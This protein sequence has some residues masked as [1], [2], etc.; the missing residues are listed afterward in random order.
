MPLWAWLLWCRFKRTEQAVMA[1]T[2]SIAIV[3][4]TY[5]GCEYI[6]DLFHSIAAQTVLPTEI[7]VC[8]DCSTDDTAATVKRLCRELA[9][10]LRFFQNERNIGFSASFFKAVSYARSEFIFFCDQDDYWHPDKINACTKLMIDNDD[11]MGVT[12]DAVIADSNLRQL[13]YTKFERF[14]SAYP[15]AQLAGPVT[16][17]LTAIRGDLIGIYLPVVREVT[18]DHWLAFIA[19]YFHWRWEFIEIPLQLVRRHERNTS[20][21]VIYKSGLASPFDLAMSQKSTVPAESYDDRI[22]VIDTLY[23]RLRQSEVLP[24][25][26]TMDEVDG[27]LSQLAEERYCVMCRAAL[28]SKSGRSLW[29]IIRCVQ[30]YRKGIYRHFNGYLSCL[31]DIARII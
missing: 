16:G 13:E 28:I 29:Y 27:V 17:C 5:N 25:N 18:Y 10:P 30:Q 15:R 14:R 7:I 31:R 22:E 24:C 9:L 3:L 26:I 2:D 11:I 8:D 19:R 12:H 6:E 23:A 1:I 21:W 20:S 4:C